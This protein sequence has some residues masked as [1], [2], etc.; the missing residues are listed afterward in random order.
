MVFVASFVADIFES[1]SYFPC[2]NGV[3]YVPPWGMYM[4]SK[5]GK[6]CVRR[7]EG[8]V[9]TGVGL[10]RKCWLCSTTWLWLED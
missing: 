9:A 4:L 6:P 5:D 2:S 10:A 1:W 7:A 3:R 8:T